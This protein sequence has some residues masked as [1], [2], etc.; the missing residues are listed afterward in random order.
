MVEFNFRGLYIC[1]IYK[2][3]YNL[4]EKKNLKIE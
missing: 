3:V 4:S 1:T 2:D